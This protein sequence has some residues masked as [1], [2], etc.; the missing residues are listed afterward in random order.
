MTA[1]ALTTSSSR[2]RIYLK[3]T[4][5]ALFWGGTFVAGRILAA[6]LPAT[7]SA[8]GRFAIAVALLIVLVWRLEGGLPK[9]S[10]R[11]LMTTVALGATGIL[12]YN[13]GFFIALARMPAGRTALFVTLNPIVTALLLVIFFRERLTP[14]RWA[15][16]LLALSGAVVVITRGDVLGGLIDISSSFGQGEL[17][18]LGAVVSWAAYTIIGRHALKGLSPLAASTY[19]AI[20]GLLLLAVAS[21]FDPQ[22]TLRQISITWQAVAAMAYIGVLGTVVAFVW[23]YQGVQMLGP[24]RTAIFNNL[25]PVFGVLS[26]ALVL[27]EPVLLSMVIGGA[28][29][30][31]GVALTNRSAPQPLQRRPA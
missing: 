30:V 11:Q 28:M 12:A 20:W 24:A 21:C 10:A 22:F 17:A 8:V 31:A 29:V 3:L 7:A 13:M 27:G 23:Y 6:S 2:F 16:I 4:L 15:G 14:T 9:L 25:V 5:V 1:L 19:A 26:G 18:M